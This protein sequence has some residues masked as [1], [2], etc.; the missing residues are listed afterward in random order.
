MDQ[1]LFDYFITEFGALPL[2]PINNPFRFMISDSMSSRIREVYEYER[3][4][5][6]I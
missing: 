4:D 1:E 2:P 3:T 5:E 6:D